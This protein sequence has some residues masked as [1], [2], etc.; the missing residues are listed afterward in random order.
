MKKI[1]LLTTMIMTGAQIFGNGNNVKNNQTQENKQ[2]NTQPLKKNCNFVNMPDVL[3][4]RV[5]TKLEKENKTKDIFCDGEGLKMVYYLIEDGIDYNLNLGVTLNLKSK[6]TFPE[7]QEFKKDFKEK[8]YEYNTFFK[9]L[10]KNNLGRIP[11]PDKEVIRFYGKI[12]GIDDRFM[13]IGKYEYDRKNDKYQMYA[14]S[15]SY[16]ELKRIGLFEGINDIKVIDE[17][18]Y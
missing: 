14:N 18:I 9:T 5:I 3:V 11:L 1:S 13:V 17:V 6:M 2:I 4:G 7:V 15:K 10:D 16:E 8:L 12:E